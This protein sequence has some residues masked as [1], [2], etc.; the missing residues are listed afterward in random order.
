MENWVLGDHDPYILG[1]WNSLS[2]GEIWWNTPANRCEKA[3]IWKSRVLGAS[4]QLDMRPFLDCM[5]S[6]HGRLLQLRVPSGNQTWQWQWTI[7]HNCLF[8][9]MIFPATK[10]HKI[11]FG[12]NFPAFSSH[13]WLRVQSSSLPVFATFHSLQPL[14]QLRC[15]LG[16]LILKPWEDFSQL[17]M[18]IHRPLG[19]RW[20]ATG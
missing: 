18:S 6:G 16:P 20:I 15:G 9:W 19:Q 11:P 4:L 3:L 10:F 14:V 7:A 17:Q 13:V 12:G 2:T 5:C 1:D 8:F